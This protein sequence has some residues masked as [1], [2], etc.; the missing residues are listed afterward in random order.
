MT[1][2][3]SC[4]ILEEVSDA[5]NIQLR[6]AREHKFLMECNKIAWWF[7]YPG[8]HTETVALGKMEKAQVQESN[9]IQRMRMAWG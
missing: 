6:T 8:W 1:F 9:Q 7:C 3:C 2:G 4:A 5:K